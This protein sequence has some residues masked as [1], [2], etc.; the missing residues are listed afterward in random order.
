MPEKR[1]P[2]GV[3][4]MDELIEGGFM[5]GSINLI[6][7]TPGTGKTTFGM[8]FLVYGAQNGERGMYISFEEKLQDMIRNLARFGWDLEGFAKKGTLE[9][10]Q[11]RLPPPQIIEMAGA[12]QYKPVEP[13]SVLDVYFGIKDR[14]ATGKF[15]RVVIDTLSVIRFARGAEKEER[16]E[17]V[18]LFR[19]LKDNNLTTLFT[20]ERKTPEEIFD[21]EDFVSDSVIQLKDHIEKMERKRGLT[22]L[23]MRGTKCDRVTRPYFITDSGVVVY[24]TEHML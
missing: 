5:P 17:L 20:V 21:Y 11:F 8:Q 9:Y 12:K 14:I 23:K 22:V 1:M 7:G 24:P 18:S 15:S 3:P 6:A 2:S 16:S 10:Q 4:G 13:P 19:F